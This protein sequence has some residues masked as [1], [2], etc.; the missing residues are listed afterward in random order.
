MQGGAIELAEQAKQQL[1]A[2]PAP[3][4]ILATDMV[5]LPAWLGLLRADLPPDVPILYYMH[6]NQLTYPPRPGEKPDLTYAMF[7]WTSQLCADCVAFN[8]HY[9]LESWFAELP[10]LLKHFPDYNHLEQVGAVRAKSRVLPVGIAAET[11]RGWEGEQAEEAKAASKKA[12]LILWNQRW[13]YDKRPAHFFDL[14]Y[15]LRD[16]NVDFRLAV[17]GENFR[18]QPAEFEAAREKLADI[19][20]QWGYVDSYTEYVALLHAADLVISTAAHEFFGISMLEA[21]VAGAF[22]LLPDRLSYPELI[23][24]ELH[25]ACLYED[26]DDLF[27]KAKHRLQAPRPAPPSLRRY[28]M[29]RFAW[30]PVS[31]AYDNVLCELCNA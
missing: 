25:P 17:A 12:P 14:L 15:R 6:E 21:I 31:A 19:I 24:A 23:P 13:E 26:A 28:V 8:S 16:Q 5:N 3:D 4:A 10:N 29:E 2:G 9:H 22:P 7:N 27:A 1:A 11:I 20:V 30:R 18:Q